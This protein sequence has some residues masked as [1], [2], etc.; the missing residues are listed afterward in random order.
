MSRNIT[1]LFLPL[2]E[3]IIG[4]LLGDG[5][6]NY[7]KTS[8]NPYF[9]FSQAFKKFD[10][11][12]DSFNFLSYLCESLPNLNISRR[13]NKLTTNIYFITRSYPFLKQLHSLF[14][15]DINGK[16]IKYI[17]DDL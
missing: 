5:S 4:H 8:V 11:F 6:I 9:H 13:N 10:Y 12:L 2:K 17:Y 14:Y 7:S 1:V 15:K 16:Y 3:Q